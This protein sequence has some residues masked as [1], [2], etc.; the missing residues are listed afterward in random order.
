MGFYIQLYSLREAAE[1]DFTGMLERVAQIGYAGVEF[2][3]YGGLSGGEMAAKLKE[4]GLEAPS[5]H[6]SAGR[7]AEHFAEEME[8]LKKVGAKYAVLPHYNMENEQQAIEAAKLFQEYALRCKEHGMTFAYH[9]HGFEFET[10]PKGAYLM[11]LVLEQ[12]PDVMLELD[13][14]WV[15]Y[16]GVDPAEYIRRWNDRI[17]MLHI[18]DIENMETK[19]CVDAGTGMLDFA[20]LRDLAVNSQYAIYEQEEYEVSCWDSAEKSFQNMKS[21][22]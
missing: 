19:R 4:L 1:Q 9:N 13:L 2:A 16:A 8:F 10:T 11:D 20:A 15:Q 12:A 5:S 7:F 3:G 18:K 6:I 17:V 22:F 21:I 14:Y